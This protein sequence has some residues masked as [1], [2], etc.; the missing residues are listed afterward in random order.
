RGSASPASAW[1]KAART[2]ALSSKKTRTFARNLKTLCA[3]SSKFPGRTATPRQAR[4]MA[5]TAS[6]T[7]KNRRLT[8]LPRLLGRAQLSQPTAAGSRKQIN[9]EKGAFAESERPFLSSFKPVL[10]TAAQRQVLYARPAIQNKAHS[11]Y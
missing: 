4:Q 5:P 3:R 6:C 7:T 11:P 2:P 9:C 1:A 10:R 8:P